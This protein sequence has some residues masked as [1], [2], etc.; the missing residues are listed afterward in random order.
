MVYTIEVLGEIIGKVLL[1]SVPLYIKISHLDLI[2]HPKESHF[3]QSG[4]LFLDSVVCYTSGC[5][6]IAMDWC[7]GLPVAHFF[8]SQS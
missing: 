6:V 5:E 8:K 1:A 7:G 4:A 3:H 2:G